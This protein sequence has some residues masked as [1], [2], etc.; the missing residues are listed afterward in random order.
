MHQI[1]RNK[2]TGLPSFWEAR[3]KDTLL[4]NRLE[5]LL[6][7]YFNKTLVVSN[8]STLVDAAHFSEA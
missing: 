1:L 8:F 5:G 4:G 6:T 2:F 3:W 7:A